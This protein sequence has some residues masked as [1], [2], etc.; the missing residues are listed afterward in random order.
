MKDIFLDDKKRIPI[1]KA[2]KEF[3]DNYQENK[4]IKGIYLHGSFGSGKS[5]MITALFNELAKKGNKSTIIYWP[6]FLRSLKAGF[7][8][9]DYDDKFETVKRSPILL[10]DDI[11]AE[12][13]TPW[14]RDE[15]LGS[16][17]QYR[18]LEHLP[19]FFTSNLNLNDLETH[20]SESK[21]NT[22]QVKA[23]RIIERIKQLSD[24]MELISPSKRS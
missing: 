9:G 17:L 20:L 1:I 10:I 16:I 22:D 15:V 8:L 11:G 14:G 12:Q 21:N 5:Y 4:N 13:I 18:M 3:I 19:T 23:R 2:L 24:S 7:S 6:E